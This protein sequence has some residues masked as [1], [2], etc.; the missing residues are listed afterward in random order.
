[1]GGVRLHDHRAARGEGGCGVATGGGEGEREIAG[2]EHR[3]GPQ[4]DLALPQ[5][6]TRQGRALRHGGIDAQAEPVALAHGGREE[7]KLPH[8]AAALAFEPRAGQAAFL[9]G[10]FDQPVAQ[11]DDPVGAGFQETRPPLQ[12]QPAIGVE[13]AFGKGTGA[14]DFVFSGGGERRLHLG[15]A[16][17]IDTAKIGGCRNARETENELAARKHGRPA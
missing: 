4:R 3:H 9:H 16:R 2:A 15:A 14:G 13:G 5:I 6:G 12:V 17:G 10:P 7:A 8:S 11:R 1:M